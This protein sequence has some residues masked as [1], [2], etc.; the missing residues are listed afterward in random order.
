[1]FYISI[2]VLYFYFYS[3]Y[4]S[5]VILLLKYYNKRLNKPKMQEIPPYLNHSLNIKNKS[6][7]FVTVSEEIESREEIT[8]QEKQ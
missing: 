8:V 6:S 7:H 3:I 4:I 1:M 2:S 5:I